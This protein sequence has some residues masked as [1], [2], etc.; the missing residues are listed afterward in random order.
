M[1]GWF[2]TNATNVTEAGKV[3]FGKD[4]SG[5][6]VGTYS[7]LTTPLGKDETA[8]TRFEEILS[9]PKVIKSML[10]PQVFPL[11][12]EAC[13]AEH[14]FMS[15]DLL[16]DFDSHL[17]KS[18][19]NIGYPL[20]IVLGLLA[21]ARQVAESDIWFEKQYAPRLY[22]ILTGFAFGEYGFC[23]LFGSDKSQ[24]GTLSEAISTFVKTCK[25]E[26]LGRRRSQVYGM[27]SEIGE[28]LSPPGAPTLSYFGETMI[29]EFCYKLW[30]ELSV[31]GRVNALRL[32][33]QEMLRTKEEGWT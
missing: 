30:G 15:D 28:K 8:R 25:I 27:L 17:E 33:H 9:D 23:D 7:R 31:F 1:K 13:F 10:D 24:K 12:L 19:P 26:G 2:M 32:F 22:K 16:D 20:A 6:L 21:G 11:V 14:R 4:L 5:A 3:L 29:N 18:R